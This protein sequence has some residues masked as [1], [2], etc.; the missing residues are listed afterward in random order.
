MDLTEICCEDVILIELAS[1]YIQFEMLCI[2]SI[3]DLSSVTKKSVNQSLNQSI[4][5]IMVILL[6]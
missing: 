3:E 2:S 4:N 1:S 6:N 5:I